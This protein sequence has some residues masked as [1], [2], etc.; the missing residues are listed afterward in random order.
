MK[1]FS[2]ERDMY[3]QVTARFISK[4]D[5][6][7]LNGAEYKLRLFDKDVFDDDFIGESSLDDNGVA[8]IR[9]KRASFNDLGNVDSKPD[10]YF[11]LLK[12]GVKLYKSKVM[13]DVDIDDIDEYKIGEGQLIDLGTFL[14]DADKS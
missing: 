11:V 14:I 10:F 9:F 8:T 7:P 6:S 1:E 12:D 2:L 5:E 13:E 3:I 4:V